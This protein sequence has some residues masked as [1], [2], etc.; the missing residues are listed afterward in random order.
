MNAT[1][2]PPVGGT[3]RPTATA[4]DAPGFFR[5]HGL[6]APG[7][8]L[9][10]SIGFPAKSTWVSAAFLMPILLLSASLWLAASAN[11]DFSAKERLG[12]TYARALMPLL[13]AAQNRRRAATAGSADLDQAQQ[14]V[15][16]ALQAVGEVEKRLGPQLN[17]AQAWKQVEQLQAGLASRAVR[18]DALA[19]FAAHTAFIDAVLALLND[20]ADSSNLTLDPD[21]DTFYLM[22]AA[23]FRL[24]S[25]IEQL[26]QLRGMGNVILRAGQKS[27]AQHDAVSVAFAFARAHREDAVKALGRAA[28]ADPALVGAVRAEEAQTSS[29]RVLDLVQQRVL[30]AAPSGDA[31]AFVDAGNVAIAASYQLVGRTLDALDQRIETRIAGLRTTLMMQMGLSLFGIMVAIYLLV[32]F[33]R[34][35]QGGI[36]EVARQ[37]TEISRG[38]LTLRPQPWGRDEVARLMNTLSATLDALRRIVGQVRA[39][40][41][42]IQTASKEVA[43]ASMD[44]SRRTEETAAQ[45]QR[46]SAAMVQI[47]GTVQH[48]AQTASGASD[49]VERS[50]LVAEKGGAEVDQV[51]TT[52]GGIKTSSCRIEEIIGTIDSIAFQTNIL[53]LNA[54]VEAARA[55]DH[56]KGFA[57]V[58]AE[59]RALAQR[60]AGAA[61][62]IK[63]LIGASVEQVE[64]GSKVVTQAGDTMR[65]IVD[66]AVRVRQLIGE[67]SDGTRAQTAGL[68]EVGQSVEQLD[69]MTQQNAALVEQTAAAAASL[70]DNARRLTEEMAFFRT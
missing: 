35:T 50:T 48:T 4:T 22:D 40:A 26:G 61:R 52:M 58:A 8:R 14:G 68:S 13:D 7:I 69:G 42:E 55:G 54:A 34:V 16:K 70:S 19:T 62:E 66:N 15:A 11:I 31:Q 51:V 49:L 1:A 28:K 29:Q 21:V 2:L 59:V 36:A 56:G 44:L 63:S 41:E 30:A 12:V 65:Q 37:L 67:I 23:V 57:V 46:T 39:G 53:A 43:A 6:L 3:A 24:P 9:F 64:G 32:A 38:N 5:H 18:D 20:M 33:Y 45:L 25:M 17:T 27:A 10:R 47:G 60:S